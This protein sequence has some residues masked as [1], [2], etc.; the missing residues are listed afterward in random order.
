M[1][2]ILSLHISCFHINWIYFQNRQAQNSILQHKYYQH[3]VTL[4]EQRELN[5]LRN[6]CYK[7]GWFLDI[8]ISAY[9][10]L[11]SQAYYSLHLEITESP[12]VGEVYSW[13]NIMEQTDPW[14]LWYHIMKICVTT[15]T[16]KGN[17]LEVFRPFAA[18]QHCGGRCFRKWTCL[19]CQWEACTCWRKRSGRGRSRVQ[20]ATKNIFLLCSI[21]WE[22]G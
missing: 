22:G 5:E 9:P 17:K 7:L 10:E 19:Q 16:C 14:V 11:R 21:W 8:P 6:T 18:M 13:L 3:K 20:P 2:T 12:D 1:I 15:P 4:K